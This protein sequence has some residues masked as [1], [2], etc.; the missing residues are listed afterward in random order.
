M[1]K[2]KNKLVYV[3]RIPRI[4]FE[5]MKILAHV[6]GFELKSDKE[7]FRICYLADVFRG[8]YRIRQ[9]WHNTEK[10]RHA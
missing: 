6:N 10:K 7:V 5:R 8:V 1:S 9:M 3:R 2:Q 4:E